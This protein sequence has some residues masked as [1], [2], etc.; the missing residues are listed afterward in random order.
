[1]QEVAELQERYMRAAGGPGAS[2]SG[3]RGE[4]G[5]GPARRQ[6]EAPHHFRFFSRCLFVVLFSCVFFPSSSLA[7]LA[8]SASA[9]ADKSKRV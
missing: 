8:A 5:H 6:L 2:P 9:Q 7:N 3:T 4:L 1:M